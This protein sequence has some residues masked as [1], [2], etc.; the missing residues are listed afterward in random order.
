[1]LSLFLIQLLSWNWQPT[2]TKCEELI[3]LARNLKPEVANYSQ[4]IYIT[5]GYFKRASGSNIG[6]GHDDD[7]G[8]S[9]EAI[10]FKKD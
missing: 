10:P 1:M 8:E 6:G 5:N 4:S 2:R 7:G 9:F 3:L